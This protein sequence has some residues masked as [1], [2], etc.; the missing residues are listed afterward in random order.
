MPRLPA[1]EDIPR[2]LMDVP[3]PLDMRAM[4]TDG[5]YAA[6]SSKLVRAMLSMTSSLNAV[7]ATGTSRT[8]CSTAR[9]ETTISSMALADA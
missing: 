3:L 2:M 5:V 6:M 9:A 4:S 7:M 1:L 8:D